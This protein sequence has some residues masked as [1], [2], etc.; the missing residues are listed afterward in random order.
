MPLEY[1]LRQMHEAMEIVFEYDHDG[2]SVPSADHSP[3]PNAS[4][5]SRHLL[6]FFPRHAAG[7]QLD[8]RLRGGDDYFAGSFTFFPPS[9]AFTFYPE[10]NQ[11]KIRI[12][13]WMRSY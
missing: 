9:L 6:P 10:A 12:W 5:R 11:T 4:L 13:S 2:E 3:S 1:A 7:I 8:P